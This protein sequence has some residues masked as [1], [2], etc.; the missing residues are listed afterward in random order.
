MG[1]YHIIENGQ[2]LNFLFNN[3][4]QMKISQFLLFIVCDNLQNL[5][6]LIT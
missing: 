2:K 5:K 6:K 1:D 4:K 3:F